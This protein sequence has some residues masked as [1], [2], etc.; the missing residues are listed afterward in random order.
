MMTS[1][2]RLGRFAL[3]LWTALGALSFA[4]TQTRGLAFVDGDAPGGLTHVSALESGGGD[5]DLAIVMGMVFGC[6]GVAWGLV[7]IRRPFGRGALLVNGG[8]VALQWV[9]LA[10][11][12]QGSVATTIVRDRNV[13]LGA[14]AACLLG[15][16]ASVIAGTRLAVSAR[17]PAERNVS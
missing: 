11:I 4:F 6:L 15:L 17:A 9:Y 8:L 14:W 5:D 12:E 13:V 16:S 1:R 3:A 7:R 10:T 2:S